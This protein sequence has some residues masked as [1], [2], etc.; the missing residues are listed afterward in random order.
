VVSMPA[1]ILFLSSGSDLSRNGQRAVRII[2]ERLRHIDNRIE[3]VSHTDP[4]PVSRRIYPTNWELGMARALSVGR[5][6]MNMGITTPLPITTYADSRFELLPAT[7]S[8][9]QKLQ[10]S[11]RVEIVIFEEQF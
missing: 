8:R 4:F 6:L 11:R 7:L 9:A 1:P 10:K 2:G 5:E 3:V